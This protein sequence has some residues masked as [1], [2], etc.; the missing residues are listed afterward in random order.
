MYKH[1]TWNSTRQSFRASYSLLALLEANQLSGEIS[2]NAED[3][4]SPSGRFRTLRIPIVFTTEICRLDIEASYEKPRTRVNLYPKLKIAGES[5]TKPRQNLLEVLI[6]TMIPKIPEK[7]CDRYLFDR[8][9]VAVKKM[10]GL[11]NGYSGDI[12]RR[13]L[14]S[15]QTAYSFKTEF[16]IPA[17]QD[18]SKVMPNLSYDEGCIVYRFDERNVG[19]LSEMLK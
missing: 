12:A 17:T 4:S 3:P 9:G 5:L 10:A 1:S 14:E 2:L 7:F 16:A 18:D 11:R 15:N 6:E 19:L 13:I 8:T